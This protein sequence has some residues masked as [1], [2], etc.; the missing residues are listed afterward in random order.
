MT[1]KVVQRTS[2]LIGLNLELE[3]HM[4]GANVS[5]EI[6]ITLFIHKQQNIYKNSIL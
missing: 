1:P 5:S 2:R 3:A 6:I 4:Y